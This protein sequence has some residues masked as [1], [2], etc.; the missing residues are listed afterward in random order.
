M[1]KD[2]ANKIYE[3]IKQ[4]MDGDFLAICAADEELD[5]MKDAFQEKLAREMYRRLLK[6]TAAWW[7]EEGRFKESCGYRRRADPNCA[8]LEPMP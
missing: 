1:N 4:A 7:E 6:P 5:R 8:C 3:A 2:R